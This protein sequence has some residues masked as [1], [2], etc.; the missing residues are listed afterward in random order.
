MSSGRSHRAPA[1]RAAAEMSNSNAPMLASL[2][3]CTDDKTGMV[4]ISKTHLG[5]H[6][7]LERQVGKSLSSSTVFL[8]K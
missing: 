3:F 2:L 5:S 8:L 6:L 4:W 7:C 1:K